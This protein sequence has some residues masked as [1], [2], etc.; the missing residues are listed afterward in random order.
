[1]EFPNPY[2]KEYIARIHK[3]MDYIEANIH[4]P[5]NLSVL[6]DVANFSP[7]HFHRIFSAMTGETLNNYLKRKRIEKAAS[8]LIDNRETPI[9]EIAEICGF[10]SLSAFARAFRERFEMNASEFRSK[11]HP[12]LSKNR[13]TQSKIGKTEPASEE[14]FWLI[15]PNEKWR[16]IMETNI[17]I[18][19][20]PAMNLICCRHTGAFDQIGKAYDK[21]FKWAGARGLLDFPKTKGVTVYHDD[22][23][24]TEIG[25]LRQSACITVEGDVKTE[26][27]IG[28]LSIPGGKY[29]VGSFII[30]PTE[31]EDAWNSVC[32]WLTES[33][34][35][36]A[37]GYPYELYHN[38]GD[39]CPEKE[40][41]VD[42]CIPVKPM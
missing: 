40:F 37:D 38:E 28:K 21:I 9:G 39:K 19:E 15:K 41:V 12:H 29:V 20:M 35:Q 34:Y 10:N 31:F 23:K 13:Q 14:Y 26:G 18:K 33:G 22:P 11:K 8:L 6:A 17:Q 5:L 3:V 25:K 27:E 36:P 32:L 1:M 24:V 4:Q 42:I 7:F 30:S 16:S 2:Q